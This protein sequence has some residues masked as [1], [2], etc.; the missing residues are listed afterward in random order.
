MFF[1]HDTTI[2]SITTF[3]PK[4]LLGVAEDQAVAPRRQ[5]TQ[6]LLEP[7]AK[8]AWQVPAPGTRASFE[9]ENMGKSMGIRF[10]S[11]LNRTRFT[12]WMSYKYKK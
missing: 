3:R 9:W 2:T 12:K 1:P 4:R 6:D 8:P 7:G 11:M 10:V 5:R